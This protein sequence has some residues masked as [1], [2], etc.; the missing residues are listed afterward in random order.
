MWDLMRGNCSQGTESGIHFQFERQG[1]FVTDL[2]DSQPDSLIFNRT[3]LLRDRRER[4][5]AQPTPAAD[6]EPEEVVVGS[7]SVYRDRARAGTAELA[8]RYESYQTEMTL[9]EEEADILTGDG[10]VKRISREEAEMLQLEDGQVL[11]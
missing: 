7:R 6:A 10:V 9:M 11:P 3:V 8:A 4:E 5:V 2:V 1:Y